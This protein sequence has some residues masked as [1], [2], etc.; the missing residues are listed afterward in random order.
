[1]CHNAKGRDSPKVIDSNPL[2][3][4]EMCQSNTSGWAIILAS[5]LLDFNERS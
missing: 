3:R 4:G 1:M 2:C 5:G